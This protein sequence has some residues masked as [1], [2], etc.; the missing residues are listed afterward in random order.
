MIK[1][2]HGET[3]AEAN[4]ELRREQKKGGAHSDADLN[5]SKKRSDDSA[6]PISEENR[7]NDAE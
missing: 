5:D 4:Q 7:E 6:D 2:D 3:I 1:N